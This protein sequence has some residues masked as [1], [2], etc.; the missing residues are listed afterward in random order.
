MKYFV[1]CMATK[2]MHSEIDFIS[3]WMRA[4]QCWIHNVWINVSDVK[5]QPRFNG[6]LKFMTY[7]DCVVRLNINLSQK[8]SSRSSNS[9]SK[10]HSFIANLIYLFMHRHRHMEYVCYQLK[11]HIHWM[12][13]NRI[14]IH[15]PEIRILS[16][17]STMKMKCEFNMCLL[18]ELCFS[19]PLSLCFDRNIILFFS[20]FF[21]IEIKQNLTDDQW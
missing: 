6:L 17:S 18:H 2:F 7:T 14:A 11:Y 5:N 4:L 21:I 16:K 3:S 10:I 12:R 1:N 8:C 20:F 19:F 15:S 9:R 13:W